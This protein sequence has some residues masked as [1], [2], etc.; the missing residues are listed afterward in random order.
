M[1]SAVAMNRR[2]SKESQGSGG[3]PPLQQGDSRTSRHGGQHKGAKVV[4]GTP[5]Q[6]CWQVLNFHEK[7]LNRIDQYIFAKENGTN[8]GSVENNVQMA[9]VMQKLHRLEQE[10]AAFSQHLMQLNKK[11]STMSLEVTEE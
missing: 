6:Q 10:N 4:K 5:V 7:R 11:S 2:I 8:E 9:E 1:S 3:L